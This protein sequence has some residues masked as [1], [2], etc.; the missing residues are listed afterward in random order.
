MLGNAL[1]S[2]IAEVEDFGGPVALVS[3][4]GLAAF[5]GAPKAHEDNQERAVRAGFR[6]QSAVDNGKN[7]RHWS[8]CTA[9]RD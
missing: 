7:R 8:A 5:F 6:M 2:A 3:G 4:T 9:H 1:A